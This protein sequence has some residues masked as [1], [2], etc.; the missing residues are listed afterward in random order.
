MS[1]TTST[2]SAAATVATTT[3][4]KVGLVLGAI[5]LFSNI[6]SVFVPTDMGNGDGPPMAILVVCTVLSVI[7][8]VACIVAWRGN[9]LALRL[10]AGATIVVTLTSLPALFVDVPVG[11]KALVAFGVVLT[12]VIVVL[13]FSTR[14]AEA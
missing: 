10:A 13:M 7:G 2:R 14:R 1:T 3:K 8:F 6:P 5:Y 11:V 12:V 4:Q 9:R